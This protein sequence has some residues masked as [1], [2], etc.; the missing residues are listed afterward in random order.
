MAEWVRPPE[1]ERGR[2]AKVLKGSRV[3]PTRH[4]F[5]IGQLKP[6]RYRVTVEVRDRTRWVVRD[7]K[8]LLEERVTWV[9][10]VL[11]KY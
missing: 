9:V 10:K 2:L 8:H 6:G 1:G 7:P 3:K 5:Q 11:P 4:Q